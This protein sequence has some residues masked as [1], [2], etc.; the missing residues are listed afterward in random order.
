MGELSRFCPGEVFTPALAKAPSTL[1]LIARAGRGRW[2][3]EFDIYPNCRVGL[4]TA[5]LIPLNR[6]T[7]DKGVSTLFFKFS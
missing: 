4:A 1:S 3:V 7:V 6:T 5:N 2:K